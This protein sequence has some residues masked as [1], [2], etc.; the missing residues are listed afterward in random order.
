MPR[1]LRYLALASL[2]LGVFIFVVLVR[3]YFVADHHIFGA[4]ATTRPMLMHYTMFGTAP[5][6]TEIDVGGGS[7]YVREVAD[8][9][10]GYYFVRN[11]YEIPLIPIAVV[12]LILP[13]MW[14]VATRKRESKAGLC[15]TCGYDLRATPDRCPECGTVTTTP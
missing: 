12:L 3:S 13:V 4:T 10:Q 11:E 7:L 2:A 9:P 15:R 6:L 5:L 14:F 8:M 1:V